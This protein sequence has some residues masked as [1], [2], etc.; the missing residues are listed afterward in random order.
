MSTWSEDM[1]LDRGVFPA[2]VAGSEEKS[3]WTTAAF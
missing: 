2:G 3:D 1:E